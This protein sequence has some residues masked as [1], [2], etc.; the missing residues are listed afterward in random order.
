MELFIENRMPVTGKTHNLAECSID[1]LCSPG[2]GI[3]P[4]CWLIFLGLL[5][6]ALSILGHALITRE[7]R[8]KRERRSQIVRG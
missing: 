4:C 6:V 5:L 3:S 7:R 2:W 8:Q 1:F